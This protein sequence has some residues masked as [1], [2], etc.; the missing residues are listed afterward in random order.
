MGRCTG[1]GSSFAPTG[2]SCAPEPSIEAGR[3]ENGGLTTVPAMWSRKPALRNEEHLAARVGLSDPA[4]SIRGFVVYAV[5][6]HCCQAGLQQVNRQ[7]GGS[8]EQD[9]AVP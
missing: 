8:R 3:S 4:K 7:P 6:G 2:R 9:Q 5:L 1:R